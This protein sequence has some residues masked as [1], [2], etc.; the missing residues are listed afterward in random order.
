[1][2]PSQKLRVPMVLVANIYAS[3]ALLGALVLVAGRRLGC[4][5]ALAPVL[6]G[7]ACFVVRMANGGPAEIRRRAPGVTR[8]Q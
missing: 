1:M 8:T 3:A 6:G 7:I 5:P 4:P 2:N